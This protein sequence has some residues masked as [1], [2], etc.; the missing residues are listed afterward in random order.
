MSHFTKRNAAVSQICGGCTDVGLPWQI[1]Q[2]LQLSGFKRI[3]AQWRYLCMNDTQRAIFD[4]RT[5]CEA[6]RWL[7]NG[8]KPLEKKVL[9]AFLGRV[10][11]VLAVAMHGEMGGMVAAFR[12]NWEAYQRA[13]LV[14]KL[15]MTSMKALSRCLVAWMDGTT[16]GLILGWNQQMREG[17]AAEARTS[18]IEGAQ[19]RLDEVQQALQK[20]GLL[21][22]KK[23][24]ARWSNDT[25]RSLL[26]TWASN[27]QSV[28]LK[29]ARAMASLAKESAAKNE[30]SAK[31][32]ELETA[33]RVMK[34][35]GARIMKR[36]LSQGFEQLKG[37]FSHHLAKLR[38]LRK[39]LAM[40]TMR[41][42]VFAWQDIKVNLTEFLK[43]QRAERMM[44]RVGARMLKKELVDL[45]TRWK[46]AWRA[47][48]EQQKHAELEAKRKAVLSMNAAEF[49]AEMQE[50]T[51][52]GE[53]ERLQQQQE[54]GERIMRG[55]AAQ[56]RNKEV[57]FCWQTLKAGFHEHL[58]RLEAERRMRK[59]G[60]RLLMREVVFAF[61]AMK[62]HLA[63]YLKQQRAERMMRRVGARLRLRDVVF[64][65]Q[66]A[67]ANLA[68]HRKKM[69][70]ETIF[71]RVGARWLM[72]ERVYAIQAMKAKVAAQKKKERGEVMMRRV[73]ARL[74]KKECVFALQAMKT[75][76]QEHKEKDRGER[77]MRRVG[78][79]MLMREVVEMMQRMKTNF[80]IFKQKARGDMIMR[81]V[82][83]KMLHKEMVYVLT[84]MKVNHL[85][86]QMKDEAET[87]MR[88][89]GAKMLMGEQL[90]AIDTW[91]ENWTI[92]RNK[93]RGE[94]LMRRVGARLTQ[95]EVV[96]CLKVWMEGLSRHREESSQERLHNAKQRRVAAFFARQ[97]MSLQELILN[98]FKRC[99]CLH[100]A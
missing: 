94:R 71:R 26:L 92:D 54:R 31:E 44:K 30:Q 4:W 41:D 15:K 70:A 6:A 63:V 27:Y 21:G 50:L 17:K 74:L 13:L 100:L 32:R 29:N 48:A 99:H 61:Q 81:R 38:A 33:Y 9:S 80:D 67:K 75:Q 76:H 60:A 12:A 11:Y 87:K 79:K 95:R 62:E 18:Y 36:E 51:A 5:K 56:W 98:A 40:L 58:Q 89:V 7:E 77:M 45:Y 20:Q 88:R 72:G 84:N 59:V 97:T 65:L 42:V 64:A 24:V 10:R 90:D 25:L 85:D 2:A 73:G 96:L 43:R 34:R 23:V 52:K 78:A 37:E 3:I 91:K 35:V 39:I 46:E 93:A 28:V 83:G 14:Q 86:A 66:Q 55:V 16:R 53:K 49:E 57:V 68:I 8:I 22:M 1:G 69:K 47:F 82:A 19:G